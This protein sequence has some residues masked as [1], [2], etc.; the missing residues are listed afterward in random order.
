[1]RSFAD[2]E[3]TATLIYYSIS[4]T[5]QIFLTISIII[6]LL[7]CRNRT[8]AVLGKTFVKHYS[9]LSVVFVESAIMNVIC[10]LFLF[11]SSIPITPSAKTWMSFSYTSYEIFLAI[12][13]AVQVCTLPL[14]RKPLVSTK[15]R[16]ALQAC[17]NYLIIYRGAKGYE[18]S[19]TDQYPVDL[20]RETIVFQHQSEVLPLDE[21][22]VAPNFSV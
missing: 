7:K 11:I 5:L 16:V 18:T 20:N 9:L 10:S 22:P 13:P 2:P 8:E 17:S 1:M 19:W 15:T 3:D 4:L 12:T 21:S 6:R 14:S